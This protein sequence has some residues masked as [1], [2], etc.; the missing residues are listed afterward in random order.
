M[1]LYCL[2]LLLSFEV[3]GVPEL[4]VQFCLEVRHLL[5]E[6]GRLGLG[7]LD[8]DL[9]LLLSGVQLGLN[10]VLTQVD[11]NLANLVWNLKLDGYY[12]Y[13]IFSIAHLQ[14]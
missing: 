8:F 9:D 4:C 12:I 10:L 7:E 3:D 6:A 11:E 14:I 2:R 5:F 1:N 13:I